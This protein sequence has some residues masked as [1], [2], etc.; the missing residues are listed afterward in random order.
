MNPIEKFRRV[1]SAI[2]H[3]DDK[4]SFSDIIESERTS[5]RGLKVTYT[6]NSKVLDIHGVE[7]HRVTEYCPLVTNTFGAR[8]VLFY[9][10]DIY[11]KTLAGETQVPVDYSVSFDKNICENVRLLAKHGTL[12]QPEE[13]RALLQLVKG[14]GT[15]SFNF[16][17]VAY[18]AEESEHFSV[19]NNNR[20]IETLKALKKLDHIDPA[21]LY[22]S[23]LT[24]EYTCDDSIVDA[25]VADTMKSV[26]HTNVLDDV[27]TRRRGTYAII[28]K[29]VLL[30]WDKN[31]T[32]GEKLKILAQYSLKNLGRFA[33]TEIYMSWKLLG[34]T[35]ST[36]PFFDPVLQPSTKCLKRIRG[37]SWD[38]TMIRIT[39]ML[40][41]MRREVQGT[42]C[43]FFVPFIASFDARFRL[44]VEAC[45][46][47]AVIVDTDLGLVNTIF[48]DELKFQYELDEA[49]IGNDIGSFS[50]QFSRVKSEIARDQLNL[51]IVELEH[52]LQRVCASC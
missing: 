16:D 40:A 43:D 26:I 29:A 50:D 37:M 1:L 20:P 52:E 51:S 24:G 38:I 10:D 5:F 39:E 48:R 46:V 33:K 9:S 25:A 13:F 23:P 21:C 45:P 28:L 32:L 41:G 30:K 47:R 17:Y 49:G 35:G 6:T 36:P 2:S 4:T 12:R 19:P 3:A 31:L 22:R 8:G 42:R 7:W 14:R 27:L 34:G 44:L 18:L 15:D 11:Q